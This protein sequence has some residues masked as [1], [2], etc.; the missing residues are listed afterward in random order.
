MTFASEDL[1]MDYLVNESQVAIPALAACIVEP[2]LSLVDTYYV[3]KAAATGR[4]L[5]DLI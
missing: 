4:I 2:A 3:G 1:I 5:I